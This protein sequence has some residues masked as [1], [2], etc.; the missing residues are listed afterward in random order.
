MPSTD[1]EQAAIR[2]QSATSLFQL[3]TSTAR[4]LGRRAG[5]AKQI[6]AAVGR[7]ADNYDIRYGSLR[8]LGMP[9]PIPLASIYTRVRVTSPD[10]FMRFVNPTELENDFRTSGRMH[11]AFS[12]DQTMDGFEI[13]RDSQLLAVIG[14]PG[15]GKSTFLKRLGQQA[16]LGGTSS[17]VQKLEKW[18]HPERYFH[19]FPVFI[20]LKK[21]RLLGRAL[22]IVPAITEELSVCGFPKTEAFVEQLLSQ[23]LLL[24]L[25]DGLDEVPVHCRDQMIRNI[26]DFKDRHSKNRIIVSCRVGAYKND[27]PDFDAV[28]VADFNDEQIAH[29]V[30]HWFRR[31]SECGVRTAEKF[32]ELLNGTNK[33]MLEL[34]RTPLLLTF[35]CICW[36]VNQQVPSS[37]VSLYREA[38]DI[39]LR[40]W[41]AEKRV[42]GEF[43]DPDFSTEFELAMLANIAYKYF[44][45]ERFFL[46]H[47]EWCSE[48]QDFM[49][50]NVK[51]PRNLSAEQILE[52][53]ETEQGLILQRTAEHWSFSHLT[54]QEYLAAQYVTSCNLQAEVCES[55]FRDTRWR[56]VFVMLAGGHSGEALVVRL[57]AQLRKLRM[58]LPNAVHDI[59]RISQF[60]TRELRSHD[61]LGD[62]IA[63]R[64][65][66]LAITMSIVCV[67]GE[68]TFVT[69]CLKRICLQL[70]T[71]SETKWSAVAI[72]AG[73][74]SGMRI[75]N[76][77]AANH[78]VVDHFTHWDDDD[79]SEIREMLRS[80]GPTSAS[81]SRMLLS[82]EEKS[83]ERKDKEVVEAM[84]VGLK[85]L[86]T[87][88]IF[89]A[90]TRDTW[91]WMYE[92][93]IEAS[94]GRGGFPIWSAASLG[95]KEGNVPVLSA[96]DVDSVARLVLS[97][98]LL[99]ECTKAAY[100]LS[101]NVWRQAMSSMFE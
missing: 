79:P 39:L 94:K 58:E 28:Y 43:I 61:A 48:I 72:L 74:E 73:K 45:Q 88:D 14:P 93:F 85:E 1:I 62:L 78:L 95:E 97:F 26:I 27:F 47:K 76:Q 33:N 82:E 71:K 41:S 87:C 36:D 25:L 15:A 42:H 19:A 96:G 91:R 81:H 20:E 86:N 70:S 10:F 44:V 32:I 8:V 101:E 12:G 64:L 50:H 35:L 69:Q 90:K 68:A 16:M 67:P 66:C 84:M 21:S 38:L 63:L 30:D 65:N 18:F 37:R 55:H 22:E 6:R 89:G 77:D 57:A 53:I 2:E 5:I 46:E 92:K 4:S 31:E 83:E 23:G 75:R 80:A 3:L 98:E 51:S 29:F 99:I 54:I 49:L 34:A 7:Y 100:S 13:A 59:L 24:V 40:K 17:F 56:E 9:K 52:F 60:M 11:R